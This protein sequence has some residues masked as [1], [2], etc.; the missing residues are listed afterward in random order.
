MCL[1]PSRQI[2]SGPSFRTPALP[3][4]RRTCKRWQALMEFDRLIATGIKSLMD[5]MGLF[6]TDRWLALIVCNLC[7]RQGVRQ[8]VFHIRRPRFLVVINDGLQLSEQMRIAK[9]VLH[10]LQRQIGWPAI[11]NDRSCQSRRDITSPGPE[12]KMTEGCR[13]QH[14]QPARLA[15]NPE[16]GLIQMLHGNTGQEFPHPI[17]KNA[18]TIGLF[19][20]QTGQRRRGD[21]DLVE[22]RE[23][24][25]Q[26]ILWNAVL[27]LQIG[28]QR[29]DFVTIL[30][31]GFH[32]LGKI[33]T[34][35]RATCPT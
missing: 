6:R 15:S 30:G 26:A 31:G 21:P 25:R 17:R 16:A 13:T 28:R 12:P 27:C 3:G 9:T 10:G 14:M 32:S 35:Q 33:S 2:M 11:V 7:Q 5:L 1:H 29:S 18:Q 19:C 22:V 8:K 34:H 20:D 4:L 23:Y 24:P